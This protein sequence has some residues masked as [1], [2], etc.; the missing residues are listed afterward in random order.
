[1]IFLNIWCKYIKEQLASA[2]SRESFKYSL[3]SYFH[4]ISLTFLR[5]NSS[6]FTCGA[7]KPINLP[8]LLTFALSFSGQAFGARIPVKNL[9]HSP[10]SGSGT[11][12]LFE[13]SD[14]KDM[15]DALNG[16]V[17]STPPSTTE[18]TLDLVNFFTPKKSGNDSD[19]DPVES[20]EKKPGLNRPAPKPKSFPLHWGTPPEVQAEDKGPLP[21]G[22]GMG[23]S[24]LAQWIETEMAADVEAVKSE[25]KP[26]EETVEVSKEEESDEAP[27]PVVVEETAEEEDLPGTEG[28][29]DPEG[30]SEKESN[31][32]MSDEE[33]A[34]VVEEKESEETSESVVVVETPKEEETDTAPMETEYSEITEGGNSD[35]AA[36]G[37]PQTNEN[38]GQGWAGDGVVDL[39]ASWKESDWFGVYWDS[40]KGWIYHLRHGWVFPEPSTGQ[41]DGCW[42][43]FPDFGWLYTGCDICPFLYAD[44]CKNWI[45][46]MQASE[47]LTAFFSFAD[48]TWFRRGEL[49]PSM[50]FSEASE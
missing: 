27:E 41:E 13:F 23:S 25:E 18:P 45:Y 11:S 42:M 36:T 10:G 21:G 35:P 7:M 9:N 46:F 3:K 5:T 19:A 8:I 26:E 48:D 31:D 32:E 24:T 1:L 22:Y 17:P 2:S 38:L 49:P 14:F 30:E 40:G 6:I 15:V 34:E 28:K 33:T 29:D 12:S 16:K 43:F 37:S 50:I 47:E 44:S 39:G 4:P 20:E